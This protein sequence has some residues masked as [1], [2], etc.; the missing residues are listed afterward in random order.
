[1]S[2]MMDPEDRIMPITTNHDLEL[3]YCPFDLLDFQKEATI[4][5]GNYGHVY[6]VQHKECGDFYAMKVMSKKRKQVEHL[7]N[8]VKMLRLVSDSPF[9]TKFYGAMETPQHLH[10]C[11]EYCPGG[12]LFRLLR[13]LGRMNHLMAAFYGAE[14]LAALEFIHGNNAM[15]RDLKPENVLI[16]KDGHL[17]LCDF[18]FAKSIQGKSWTLCGTSEYLA[19]EVILGMGHDKAVDFWAFGVFLYEL[20]AGYPPFHGKTHLETYDQILDGIY[21][22][23]THFP[24][25]AKDIITRLLEPSPSLRLGN[26]VGGIEELKRHPFFHSIDW[27]LLYRKEIDPPAVP[28][29]DGDDDHSHFEV[30]PDTGVSPRSFGDW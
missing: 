2:T 22:L 19:P 12:E 18:G 27:E 13:D 7:S 8:E 10:I 28:T 15:Y 3:G 1:M 11:I 25:Q 9:V 29:L 16:G 14:V 23:P 6:L 17:K 5:T 30:N 20:L 4:G 26:L 24:F 21:T